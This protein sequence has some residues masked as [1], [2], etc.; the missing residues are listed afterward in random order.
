MQVMNVPAGCLQ[1]RI[2][3]RRK[4]L[5]ECPLFRFLVESG[6]TGIPYP[7]RRRPEAGVRFGASTLID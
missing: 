2:D 6:L 7:G 4:P 3:L 1:V 5:D